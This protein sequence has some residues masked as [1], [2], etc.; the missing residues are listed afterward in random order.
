MKKRKQKV[1]YDRKSN[2]NLTQ[3][4]QTININA[5]INVQQ[6]YVHKTNNE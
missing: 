6:L 5:R 1:N 2:L 4:E 3:E